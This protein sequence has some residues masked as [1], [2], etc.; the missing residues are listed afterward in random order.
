M[1]KI[2]DEKKTKL[3]KLLEIAK[4]QKNFEIKLYWKRALY[5]LGFIVSIY[6]AFFAVLM[7]EQDSS[8]LKNIIL[9]VLSFLGY[10]FC[11]GFYYSNIGS[12][13]WQKKLGVACQHIGVDRRR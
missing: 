10:I 3:N 1:K 12:K 9:T 4:A 11:L 7:A 8:L 13:H 5:F 2:S 6:T